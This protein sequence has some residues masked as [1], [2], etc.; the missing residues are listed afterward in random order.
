MI[1]TPSGMN[2]RDVRRAVEELLE[3]FIGAGFDH[4]GAVARH[5]AVTGL[6][7]SQIQDE[8]QERSTTGRDPATCRR[9]MG[10]R[11]TPAAGCR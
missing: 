1:L 9:D 10:W 7:Y 8:L 11:A 5:A 4:H 3:L 6:L 2:G